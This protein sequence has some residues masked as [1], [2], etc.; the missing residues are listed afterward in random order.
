MF[1][2]VCVLTQV[3]MRSKVDVV[4]LGQGQTALAAKL[5][6]DGR[7]HG[8]WVLL[9]V[10][11]LTPCCPCTPLLCSHSDTLR[12]TATSRARGWRSCNGWWRASSR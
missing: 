1:L 4:S 7:M 8:H 11:P 10:C 9:Q 5:I 6:S 2:C 3:G 12:R